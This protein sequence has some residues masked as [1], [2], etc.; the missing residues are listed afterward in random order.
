[1]TE[2]RYEDILVERDDGI[3]WLTI[4]RPEQANQFRFETARELADALRWFRDTADDRVAVITGAG[5][6][7]FCIGGEKP[8]V[9]GFDQSTVMPIVDVYELIDAVPKPVI[10]MV[11]GY[12]VGGGHVLHVVSDLTIASDRAVFRQVGPSMGS[13]DAGYGTWLLEDAIGRKRAKEMWYLNEKYDAAEALAMGLVNE[14]VPHER[15]RERTREVAVALTRR[16]PQALA[17]LKAAFSARNTGVVGQARIA[18]DQLLRHYLVTEESAEMARSFR[19]K[20]TPD[21]NRLN[22]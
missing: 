12:A 2:R 19:A 8:K 20:E 1:M 11:N 6:R 22:R 16:G 3:V 17:G 7:F 14:V 21:P 15:L 5:D 4:N 13:F 18:H 10:A 9:T